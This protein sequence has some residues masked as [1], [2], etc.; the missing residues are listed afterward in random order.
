MHS[1]TPT[2]APEPGD[3]LVVNGSQVLA[4]SDDIDAKAL[5]LISRFV[6]AGDRV[7]IAGFKMNLSGSLTMDVVGNASNNVFT[8]ISLGNSATSEGSLTV[9]EKL[10]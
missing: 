10:K 9:Q 4:L 3:S 8:E 7:D 6:D 5:L 1:V 2:T